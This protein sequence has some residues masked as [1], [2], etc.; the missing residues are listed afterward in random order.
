MK[1]MEQ[2]EK[3][4]MSIR[5]EFEQRAEKRRRTRDAIGD[6]SMFKEERITFSKKKDTVSDDIRTSSYKFRGYDP[7]M[8]NRKKNKKKSVKAFKSKSKYKRR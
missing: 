4:T 2:K 3:S 8:E 1:E 6:S 5:E 7:D